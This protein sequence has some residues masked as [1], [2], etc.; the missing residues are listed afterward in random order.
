MLRLYAEDP[1]SHIQE[2]RDILEYF[3]P[4]DDPF[5][6]TINDG[7]SAKQRQI[8]VPTYLEVIVYNAVSN[9]L[10]MIF[11]RHFY[12]HSYASIPK[13]GTHKC[14]HRIEKWIRGRKNLYVYSLDIRGFFK[15]VRRN[16]LSR[17][18]RKVIND[19]RFYEF[20]MMILWSTPRHMGLPLGFPTS[21][22]LANFYL[23]ETDFFIAH[24]HGVYKFARFMDNM[25]VFSYSKETINE[26][27]HELRKHLLTLDLEIKHGYM[28]FPLRGGLFIDFLGY[29]IYHNH[30]TLRRKLALKIAR[31]ARRIHRQS[32]VNIHSVRQMVTYLGY[33]KHVQCYGFFCRQ[34]KPNVNPKRLRAYVSLKDKQRL[35]A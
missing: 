3:E 2:I 32:V 21:Q 9:V 11:T 22:W 28:V 24:Q 8:I 30:T 1:E 16:I 31:K 25:V 27:K 13:R 34:I 5:I 23:T 15:H 18:L 29:R 35:A 19:K 26:L 17:K 7:I 10:R 33:F 20:L 4:N 14:L 6:K 12:E